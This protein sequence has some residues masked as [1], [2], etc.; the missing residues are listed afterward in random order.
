MRTLNIIRKTKTVFS[1]LI[2]KR[3][4]DK[5]IAEGP[6]GIKQVLH[7]WFFFKDDRGLKIFKF[8]CGG[9]SYGRERENPNP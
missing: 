7:D 5:V 6:Y 4:S 1:D 2:F 3:E 8:C 9:L